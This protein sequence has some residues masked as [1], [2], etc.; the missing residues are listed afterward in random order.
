MFYLYTRNNYWYKQF[1][2]LKVR[3][4]GEDLKDGR[5]KIDDIILYM[6]HSDYNIM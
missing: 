6:A 5:N 4:F 1:N 3:I 2:I